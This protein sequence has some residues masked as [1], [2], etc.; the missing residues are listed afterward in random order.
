MTARELIGPAPAA[1]AGSFNTDLNRLAGYGDALFPC[2]LAE[3]RLGIAMDT[4]RIA[5]VNDLFVVKA[6]GE[7]VALPWRAAR[8]QGGLVTPEHW[9]Y[10]QHDYKRP[11]LGEAVQEAIEAGGRSFH[12][13]GGI[14]WGRGRPVNHDALDTHAGGIMEFFKAAQALR[15]KHP[16]PY[17]LRQPQQHP[18]Y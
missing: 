3:E 6:E 4:G 8:V 16:E 2:R 11:L 15:E 1:E 13:D 17:L 9:Y 5:L 10:M 12:V 18:V 14:S 7:A